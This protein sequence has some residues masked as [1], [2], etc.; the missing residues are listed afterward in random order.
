MCGP[1]LEQANWE[2]SFQLQLVPQ[3][4]TVHRAV[5]KQDEIREVRVNSL[6]TSR[7]QIVLALDWHLLPA[8]EERADPP[9]FPEQA[10]I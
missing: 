2:A 8:C 7:Q 3:P 10:W 6:E 5:W 4:W 9:G 1:T